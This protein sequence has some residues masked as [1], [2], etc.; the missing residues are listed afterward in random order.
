MSAFPS[1]F[2]HIH[3]RDAHDDDI[4]AMTKI[5]AWHVI[6]GCASF[7]EIPPDE[8]EMAARRA[9]VLRLGL[10][11]LVAEQ[12][13]T[14][15][16]FCYASEYRPRPAYRFTIESSIYLAAE[17]GGRGI[18]SALMHELL[19]RCE[20]GPWRQM[21]AI[22]GNGERN[23]ASYKLH[24]RMGF[25]VVGTLH[26]VGFKHGEWRDTLLMQRAL[27]PSSPVCEEGQ[28]CVTQ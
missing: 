23:P 24:A 5:Y 21:L 4:S 18:G 22:I 12:A 19:T 2:N 6:Y 25:E 7:E 3:I 15:V 26:N 1:S 11:Y 20:R 27:I 9:K 10:P 28:G 17:A 16:G 14:L 8:A 13:G